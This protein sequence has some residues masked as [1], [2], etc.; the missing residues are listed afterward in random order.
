MGGPLGLTDKD[1]RRR[2]PNRA[3]CGDCGHSG[4]AGDWFMLHEALARLTELTEPALL[5]REEAMQPNEILMDLPVRSVPANGQHR[6]RIV[7]E[8]PPGCP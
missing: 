4:N 7:T 3:T 1:A 6:F 2:D 5:T 8:L